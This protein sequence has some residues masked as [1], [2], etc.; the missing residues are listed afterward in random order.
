MPVAAIIPAAG[1]GVRMGPGAPKAMRELAGE[2]LLA[3]AVRSLVSTHEVDQLVVVVAA[4]RVDD[5]RRLLEDGGVLAATGGRVDPSSHASQLRVVAGGSSRR[6]S[7][8][9]G[10]RA[11]DPDTDVVLVHDA[12]RPLVPAEVVARV[13]AAVRAGAPAVVPVLAVTDTIKRVRGDEV[14]ETVDRSALR[15]AQTPQGFSRTA[16]QR[17]HAE[18]TSV[19]TDDAGMVEELGLTVRVVDGHAEAFKITHAFD[20]AVAESVLRGRG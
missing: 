3:H 12:A 4:D 15:A 18:T 17:A 20:L 9:A 1:L 19:A 7:V 5:V 6:E 14:V 8:A 11:V 2:P 13:V 16:L 10:L